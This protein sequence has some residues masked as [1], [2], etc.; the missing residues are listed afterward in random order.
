MQKVQFKGRKRTK[1]VGIDKTLQK[2][3]ILNK[4]EKKTIKL[5]QKIIS[6]FLYGERVRQSTKN[7]VFDQTRCCSFGAIQ[8][9]QEQASV[10]GGKTI[11]GQKR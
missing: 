11:A 1:V 3:Q 4:L 7:D 8:L 9:P 2:C 5:K 6:N 10:H